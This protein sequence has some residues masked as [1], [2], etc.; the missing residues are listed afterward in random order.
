M[1]APVPPP[2]APALCWDCRRVLAPADRY[3]RVCGQGQGE[4]VAWYYRRWGIA[5]ATLLGLGPFGLVLV[6]RTPVMEARER[7]AWAGAILALT[8]WVGW[9]LYQALRMLSDALRLAGGLA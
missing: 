6:R 3:C 1:D 5:L 9:R 2:P 7:W 4:W 8:A